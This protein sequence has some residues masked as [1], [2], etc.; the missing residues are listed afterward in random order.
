MGNTAFKTFVYSFSVS[1]FAIFAANRAFFHT[2]DRQT[3]P[4]KIPEKNITLFLKDSRLN[5]INAAVPTKKIVLSSVADIPLPSQ[6]DELVPE[7][8]DTEGHNLERESALLAN[9]DVIA[10]K[11]P[12]VFEENISDIDEPSAPIETVEKMTPPASS[13]SQPVVS[14]K[15]EESILSDTNEHIAK[16]EENIPILSEKKVVYLPEQE[17]QNLFSHPEEEKTSPVLPDNK[18][19]S[20]D[21]KVV[22]EINAPK[23]LL[24]Q[25]S[26]QIAANEAPTVTQ[27]QSAAA[28]TENNL[29]PLEIVADTSS[30]IQ[31]KV[32]SSDN[33]VQNQVALNAQNTPIKSMKTQKAP[34]PATETSNTTKE[35]E[36]MA[37]K[38][39]KAKSDS[40]WVVA[41]GNSFP[42]NQMMMQDEHFQKSDEEIKKIFNA[43][44]DKQA[45]ANDEKNQNIQLASETVQNLLIPIPEDILNDENLVPQLVSSPR[46]QEIKEELEA[47]GLIRKE[48]PKEEPEKET[49]VSKDTESKEGKSTDTSSILNS[50][51]SLFSKEGK[52]EELPELGNSVEDDN[53]S[54]N[55][56]FSAFTRKQNR[57]MTKILPTEIR[58]SFQ[59][60]RA[61]ISG[62]T[63]KWIKAFAQKTAE[64]QSTGLEIRI[65]GTSSPVLQR[66]RLNLLQNILI[67]EGAS[68]EKIHTVFTAREPN[69]FILRT[70]K[71]NTEKSNL[72]AK[73]NNRYMQW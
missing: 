21:N 33:A 49:Q 40:P 22:A 9:A 61:E 68:P 7:K 55:S 48:E 47:K 44:P 19:L 15:N 62:Q 45:S 13:I 24:P 1:L 60:N 56:L 42:A 58:L 64:E 27:P 57:L 32:I 41:K 30:A 31:A 65:D 50:L 35:W 39:A 38:K 16:Q 66:R 14:A 71:I 29:I 10:D 36:T 12:V 6:K 26:V 37:Q 54:Q 59:P 53:E 18:V 43:H 63:L 52:E 51:T 3:Q 46:N 73:N 23:S 5:P 11:I 72:P 17:E 70:T 34:A 28:Q 20:A 8:T 67:N 69:S 2:L 4:I 25:E